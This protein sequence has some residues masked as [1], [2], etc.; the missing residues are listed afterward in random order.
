MITAMMLTLAI[1]SVGEVEVR[2]VD[3]DGAPVVGAEVARLF[4]RDGYRG[5]QPPADGGHRMLPIG[6]AAR[7]GDDGV[8]TLRVDQ[9]EWPRP[10]LLYSADQTYGALVVVDESTTSPLTVTAS[11]LTTV[12]GSFVMEELGRTPVWMNNYLYPVLPKKGRGTR[13][14]TCATI[15][16][17]FELRL[18]RGQYWWEGFGDE[19]EMHR[20]G[21]RV[22][23]TRAL[24]DFEEIEVIP[25]VVAKA[26]GKPLPP[27]TA[28]AARGIEPS[29]T[30]ADFKG[31]HLLV[32]YW[33]YW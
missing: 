1:G 5:E 10:F 2:V 12:R 24:I 11:P 32:Y 21:V 30:P 16:G 3:A 6:R 22:D 4:G 14:A 26:V 17:T 23:G 29:A 28:H 33:A 8:L 19:I 25:N 7:T 20:M 18:P 13:I 27:W 15:D 9:S 31:K